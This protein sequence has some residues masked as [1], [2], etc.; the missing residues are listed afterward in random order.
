MRTIFTIIGIIAIAYIVST[1]Q[2]LTCAKETFKVTK[3]FVTSTV[4]VT[5]STVKK[6]K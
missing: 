6:Q 3:N 2:V 5:E 4:D 1:G